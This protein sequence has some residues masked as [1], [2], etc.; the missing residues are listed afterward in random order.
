MGVTTWNTRTQLSELI[1]MFTQGAHTYDA[2]EEVEQEVFV[3]TKERG[4]N[5]SKTLDN[6]SPPKVD[7]GKARYVTRG[8][9]KRKASCSKT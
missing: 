1:L 9:N 2:E 6:L 3:P 4:A 7:K 5:L 8:S